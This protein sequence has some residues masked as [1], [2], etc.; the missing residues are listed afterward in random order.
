MSTISE[1]IGIP[2]M[3]MTTMAYAN[4]FERY[5]QI[6]ERIGSGKHQEKKGADKTDL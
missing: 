6:T 4:T 2:A 1:E 3:E 5:Q